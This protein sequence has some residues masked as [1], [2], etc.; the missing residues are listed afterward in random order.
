MSDTTEFLG[1]RFAP[2]RP[3]A[4]LERIVAR[5]NEAAPFVYVVTPNV[6]HV[7]ALTRE[8]ERRAPLYTAAWLTLNDSRVLEVLAR[9]S[10]VEL[11]ACPGADLT[12]ALFDGIDP[13]E[14]VVIVGGSEATVSGLQRRYRL[15][16]V[17]WHPPP[18]GLADNPA[19]IARAAQ[20]IATHR[21]R[22]VFLALGAPQQEMVAKAA[23]ERGDCFGV[24]LCIGASLDFLAGVQ[25]RAPQW[26][27]ERRLEWLHRLL[28]EPR[29]LGRRYLRDGPRIFGIWLAW[30]KRQRATS[31]AAMTS[32]S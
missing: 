10:H 5:A 4:A 32:R 29:R 30:R 9:W 13:V 2:L 26:M 8:Y 31:R 19:A 6:D 18:M 24:G 17:R 27:R 25:V 23:L 1:V 28:R 21:A 22:F 20:F 11:P 3:E 15:Q 16:D 14:P 12:A 7:V